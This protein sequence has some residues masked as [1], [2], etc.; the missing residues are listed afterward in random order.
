MTTI[1]CTLKTFLGRYLLFNALANQLRFP[2]A[3]THYFACTLLYLFKESTSDAIK[4]QITRYVFIYFCT[5][6]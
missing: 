4:E 1:N 6:I 2:N 3:Q 5:N